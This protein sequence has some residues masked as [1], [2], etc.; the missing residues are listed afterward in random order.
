MEV[1]PCSKGERND[2]K[3]KKDYE[4]TVKLLSSPFTWVLMFMAIISILD[5]LVKE[6]W[7]Y[8]SKMLGL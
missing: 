6:G 2:W 4:E 7:P 5:L 8:L 1:L 3:R